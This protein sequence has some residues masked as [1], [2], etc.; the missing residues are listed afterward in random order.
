MHIRH[1]AF[2]GG[3][4]MVL[5]LAQGP[6]AA[7]TQT[8]D[9]KA[10]TTGQTWTAPRAADGHADLQGVWANNN[11]T[12]MQRPKGLE[13]RATLTDAEVT[14]LRKK[15]AELYDGSGD[16]E[17]GDTYFETVWTAVQNG[18]TGTHKK[19]RNGQDPVKG[20]DAGTGD[21][22]SAW[23]VG[24]DWDNRTSLLIDPPDGRM[25]ALTAAGKMAQASRKSYDEESKD[26][27]R[28]DSYED[29]SLGVRCI[30]FGSPRIGAGYNSYYQIV[31]TP[32]AV[33][34]QM[35][36]A[37]DVRVIPLDG[38]PHL[39]STVSTWMGDSRGH[40]E[41]D[42]LVVDTT[43]YKAGAFM[44]AS[45]KL[46]VIERFTRTAPDV[47]QYQITIN[48]PV[49]W[50]KPWTVMIPMRRSKDAIYEYACHEGNYGLEG[51]L[52]GARAEDAKDA[53]AIGTR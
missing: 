9:V 43:N 47:L 27:K 6:V 50:T 7:Q 32:E 39:P 10:K 41:G 18:E 21:Y 37:H 31:Q 15:A 35:E 36:M 11:A 29:I 4:A 46:H 42:T 12:P 49:T 22:S 45:D 2:S 23:L 40:W 48:D 28:P 38:S 24:R 34:F 14:A 51:I 16:T 33:A 30:T 25:P 44:T 26:G 19:G 3:L 17:F 53:K 20:F 52:G 5:A 13:G 1:F 8:L